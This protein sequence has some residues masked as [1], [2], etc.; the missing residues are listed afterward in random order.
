[1][2]MAPGGLL[3]PEKKKNQREKKEG[4]ETSAAPKGMLAIVDRWK[5][6]R[7]MTREYKVTEKSGWG[8]ITA[9]RF[10]ARKKNQGE[11]GLGQRGY[12]SR[13]KKG[14]KL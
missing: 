13:E 4:E 1:M 9:I 5:K 6:K 3:R 11:V 10:W 12:D 2:S 8:K 7:K 14:V